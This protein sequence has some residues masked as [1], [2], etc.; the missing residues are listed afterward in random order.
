MDKKEFINELKPHI[1]AKKKRS[2]K[3]YIN[4]YKTLSN[5]F[6]NM[7]IMIIVIILLIIV[8][9]MSTRI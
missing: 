3:E 7:L 1:T 6:L 4:S 2:E 8:I 5:S 9:F